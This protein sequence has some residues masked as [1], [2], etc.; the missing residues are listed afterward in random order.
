MTLSDTAK[1]IIKGQPLLKIVM[2]ELM[3]VTPITIQRWIKA[4]HPILTTAAMVNLLSQKTGLSQEQLLAPTKN[5][6]SNS[7]KPENIPA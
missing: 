4:D 3:H 2:A 6:D 7:V 5:V 1:A